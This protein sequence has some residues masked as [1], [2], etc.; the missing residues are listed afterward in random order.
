MFPEKKPSLL[1]YYNRFLYELIYTENAFE[2]VV[3]AFK[4]ND[5]YFASILP[6]CLLD[7]TE[8]TNDS[9]LCTIT[10]HKTRYCC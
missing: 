4:H 6:K 5:T 1:N 10:Y 7:L 2:F 9:L 8:E 3:T